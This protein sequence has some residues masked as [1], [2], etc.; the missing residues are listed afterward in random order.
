LIY[1]NLLILE[2]YEFS[3][4]NQ[5]LLSLFDDLNVFLS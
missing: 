5:I 3:Y 2:I 1:L 4:F